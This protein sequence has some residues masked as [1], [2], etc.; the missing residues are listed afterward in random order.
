MKNAPGE[1]NKRAAKIYH[2]NALLQTSG[3]I[4]PAFVEVDEAGIIQ[5]ISNDAP[6]SKT[7][8]EVVNGFAV[9]GFQNAHSHAFQFAM[10]GMAEKHD[11]NTLDDF[12][13]WREA[14]YTCALTLD[15]QQMLDV[16]AML[17]A[18]MLK[19]GYTHVAEFQYLH[20]DKNGKPYDNQAEMSISLV[21]AA[22]LAGIKITLIPVYYHNGG[23]GKQA[24]PAQRRF[25]FQDVDQ[26]LELLENCSRIVKPLSTARLGFGVH[27]LR[28]AETRDIIRIATEGPAEIPFHIH[29]AEQLREVNDALAFLRQ[30]PVEW[31]L[32]NLSLNDRF[33]LVH[34][35]HLTDTEVARLAQT[36]ANVV[37]CPGTEANLGDGIFRLTD[38]A[39]QSDRWSIG[40]DSHISLNPLEDLRW[41]DY[42]QRLTSHRRNTFADGASVLLK[43]T[44]LSG[45]RSM[46]LSCNNFFEIGQPLDAVVY[47]GSSPLLNLAG[48]EHLLSRLIYTSDS[49]SVSGTIVDGAWISKDHRHKNEEELLNGFRSAL[50]DISAQL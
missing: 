39:L 38:F 2:F 20:H 48:G 3:W 21:A 11:V 25:C 49:S 31:M 24:E 30:R 36:R 33:H 26:Y 37:L 41:L 42:T 40:T 8:V 19:R 28:A 7:P 15:P 27:S 12:W 35:T 32:N 16:A 34:C 47:N 13:S 43:N 46:G 9:P 1:Q 44:F 17:Y 29:V 5:R 18:E 45:R 50:K 23:F 10:A 6:E 22:A 14:M 4:N